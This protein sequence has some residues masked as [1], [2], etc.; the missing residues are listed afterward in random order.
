MV[1]WLWKI[2]DY[3]VGTGAAAGSIKPARTLSKQLL[4]YTGR[5]VRG[6][7]GTIAWLPHALHTAA[8]YSR[9][10]PIRTRL[11]F[12]RQLGQRCGTFW[13]PFSAKNR[14]SPLE[15]MKASPQSRHVSVRSSYT[16]SV[17]P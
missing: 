4:Q 10:P 16:A 13:R 9:G 6:A 1:D 2:A 11:A 14:C 3:D 5:S 8:W 17:L 7:K 12:A 15:K